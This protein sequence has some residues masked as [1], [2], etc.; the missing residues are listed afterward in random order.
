MRT[1][2]YGSGSIP[3]RIGVRRI[4]SDILKASAKERRSFPKRW[5]RIAEFQVLLAELIE[6]VDRE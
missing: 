1:S 4:C 3:S 5:F 2:G 6:G